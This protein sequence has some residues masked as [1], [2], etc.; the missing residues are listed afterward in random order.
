ME[1]LRFI[2]PAVVPLIL[3]SVMFIRHTL[4]NLNGNTGILKMI[5]IAMLV[6]IQGTWGIQGS[7]E[8]MENMWFRNIKQK[9]ICTYQW[10]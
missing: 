7:I 9:Y 6:L 1:F 3:L 5:T 4:A 10:E 2:Q 8:H